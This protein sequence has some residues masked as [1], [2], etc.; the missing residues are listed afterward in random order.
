MYQVNLRR[1]DICY[2]KKNRGKSQ[3][4]SKTSEDP[5]TSEVLLLKQSQNKL[6]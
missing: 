6:R 5:Q 3:I 4:I 2:Q 1:L